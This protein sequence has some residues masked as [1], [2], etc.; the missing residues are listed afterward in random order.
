M[1]N[2]FTKYGS[3]KYNP[4]PIG[5]YRYNVYDSPN[6][7]VYIPKGNLKNFPNELSSKRLQRGIIPME[8]L[9]YI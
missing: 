3:N 2:I 7:I 5:D 8:A 9:N 1:S 4:F 6:S